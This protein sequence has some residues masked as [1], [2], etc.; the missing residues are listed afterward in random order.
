VNCSA[1]LSDDKKY[2]YQ[3]TRSWSG[4]DGDGTRREPLAWIMLNP[5][6]ADA[7]RDDATIR[8]CIG[9]S[10]NWGFGGI[11]VYNL[12]ALRA[13]NPVALLESKD[14][15]GEKNDEYLKAIPAE[16]QI[17]CAWGAFPHYADRL[18]GREKHVLMMLTGRNIRCLGYTKNGY[19]R[20]P[21]RLPYSTQLEEVLVPQPAEGAR[22]HS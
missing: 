16:R 15:V 22:G 8:R 13:T 2:R 21:V 14:P 7:S 18:V 9:F 11:E 17:I 3:L 4:D 12:F 20:H 6:T 10:L 5:S 1:M 19:P